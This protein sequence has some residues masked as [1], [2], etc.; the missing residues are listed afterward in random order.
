MYSS[1]DNSGKTAV[2]D[3]Q[4]VFFISTQ[5][6]SIYVAI[7]MYFDSLQSNKPSE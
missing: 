3:A 4:N 5:Q 7:C 6:Y 2:V 1:K